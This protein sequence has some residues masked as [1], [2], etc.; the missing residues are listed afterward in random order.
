MPLSFP[1]PEWDLYNNQYGFRNNHSAI[2]ALID[3]TEKIRNALDNQY[4]ACADFNDLE[5]AFDTVNHAI[6]LDKLKCYGV[7][8]YIRF[9]P[10]AIAISTVY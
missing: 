8:G 4:N 1:R 3:T 2:H 5:K 7:R 10:S 9:S 6:L